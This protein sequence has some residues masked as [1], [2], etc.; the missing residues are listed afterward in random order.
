M[1]AAEGTGRS[2]FGN[3][4]RC[5]AKPFLGA[6]EL[7]ALQEMAEGTAG[8]GRYPSADVRPVEANAGGETRYTG[9]LAL[10]VTHAQVEVDGPLEALAVAMRG[11]LHRENATLE[12]RSRQLGL[13][14]WVPAAQLVEDDNDQ[15]LDALAEFAAGRSRLGSHGLH[16]EN[17][18]QREYCQGSKRHT[19]HKP[20][21]VRRW[22]ETTFGRAP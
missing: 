5:E 18:E 1:P 14:L 17:D 3:G 7:P 22:P 9:D 13:T 8:Q 19:S 21:W 12:L 6:L 11:P 4:E 15:V 10:A 20:S 16:A 2:D